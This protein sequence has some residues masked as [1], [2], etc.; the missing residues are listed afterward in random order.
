M[1]LILNDYDLNYRMFD[2]VMAAPIIIDGEQFDYNGS[3]WVTM[4]DANGTFKV[5]DPETKQVNVVS[6]SGDIMTPENLTV[7][8]MPAGEQAKDLIKKYLTVKN[9]LI[10]GGL[11]FLY[12]KVI[13][14]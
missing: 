10:L 14:K 5:Y 4:P 2:G 11:Y 6:Q 8:N 1:P 13:K 7:T 3:M 12:K 9:L